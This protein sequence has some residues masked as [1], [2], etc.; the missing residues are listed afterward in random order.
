MTNY[1]ATAEMCLPEQLQMRAD[2]VAGCS[3]RPDFSP[4]QPW[5]A[6]TRR[7]PS[8]AAGNARLNTEVRIVWRSQVITHRSAFP[9]WRP[10]STAG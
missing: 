4:A 7:V 5:R 9:G 1:D 2:V 3:E 8:K 6:K 10:L